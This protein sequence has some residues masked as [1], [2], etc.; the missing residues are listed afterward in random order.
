MSGVLDPDA[1]IMKTS[2]R[3]RPCLCQG[4]VPGIRKRVIQP[5]VTT[6]KTTSSPWSSG[7]LPVPRPTCGPSRTTA[8]R[9]QGSRTL[10]RTSCT[11]LSATTPSAWQQLKG[12]SLPTGGSRTRPMSGQPPQARITRAHPHQR[13]PHPPL[14]PLRL[15]C[16]PATAQP[17][18][19]TAARTP[20]QPITRGACSR[21]GGVKVFYR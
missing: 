5:R 14:H 13:S 10:S 16:S 6:R 3:Q 9:G 12:P 7:V 18:C 2:G 17:H 15:R 1:R 19:A 8:P 4:C 20:S 11:A 21:H